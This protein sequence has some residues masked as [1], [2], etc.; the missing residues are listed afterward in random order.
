MHWLA[1]ICVMSCQKLD[2]IFNAFLIFYF[3]IFKYSLSRAQHLVLCIEIHKI[4]QLCIK[5]RKHIKN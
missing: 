2:P 4:Q 5:F 1:E 3:F